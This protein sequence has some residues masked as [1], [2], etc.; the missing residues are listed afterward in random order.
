MKIYTDAD[1]AGDKETRVSVSG[2][3][4]FFCSVAI[5]WRS[6]GQKSVA[7]SSGESE[8]ISLSEAA[9][10]V[11]FVAMLLK[12]MRV[13]VKQPIEVRVDNVGAIGMAESP[14]TSSRSRHIDTRYHFVRRMVTD[15]EIRIVFTPT[16][17]N[18]ADIFTKNVKSE[19]YD[20]HA[21]RLIAEK[22]E[23]IEEP[24]SKLYYS[25]RVSERE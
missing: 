24:D 1:W 23:L 14:S 12:S 7:L 17:D 5:M 13:K 10:E 15:G 21:K 4:L 3:V 19:I 2:F 18:V 22:D 11:K 16:D 8:Y 6:C 9:K 25:G 20:R